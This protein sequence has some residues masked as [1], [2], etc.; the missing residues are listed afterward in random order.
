MNKIKKILDIQQEH[1]FFPDGNPIAFRFTNSRHTKV[2]MHKDL[3]EI[4][5][6]FKG[7][8]SI[9]CNE[10]HI[11]ISPG[12]IFTI[13]PY[14]VY[15]I[16][17]DEDNLLLHFYIDLEAMGLTQNE[18]SLLYLYVCDH[19]A[20]SI[21]N[22]ALTVIKQIIL[23]LVY[24]Q[25]H[26]SPTDISEN[27]KELTKMLI[28]VMSE[29]FDWINSNKLFTASN[30]TADQ[31]QRLIKIMA[32]CRDHFTEKLTIESLSELV[33]I[34]P[35]YF[36]QFMKDSPYGGFKRMLGYMRCFYSQ[37]L[38]LSSDFSISK[39]AELC[40]FSDMTHYNKQFSD[41]W[42]KSPSEYRKWFR[43]YIKIETYVQ[44]ISSDEAYDLL[45]DI[46]V[47]CISQNLNKYLKNFI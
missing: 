18:S 40:G 42:H 33:H 2:K 41:T 43:E 14:D 25:M 17:S 37:N 22:A 28:R 21:Q 9:L 38:L 47:D 6:C 44:E 26:D 10:D 15:C 20:S 11:V 1:I 7:H 29:H 45:K 30:S 16:H 3:C 5:Y 24:Q 39:I 35:N 23:V 4:V 36:S 13:A 34:T 31:R 12:Q 27:R 19:F 32:Y 8:A 46:M